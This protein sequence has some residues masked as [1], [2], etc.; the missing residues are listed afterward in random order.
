MLA[1]GLLVLVAIVLDAIR[2]VRRSRYEKIR[3]PRRKQPIFDDDT[4]LDEYGSELPS[5]GARVVAQRDQADLEEMTRSL[6]DIAEASKPKLTIPVRKP[7]QSALDLGEQ[8]EQVV[9][10][11]QEKEDAQQ[12]PDHST[13]QA[14][15]AGKVSGQVLVLHLMATERTPFKGDL[16]LNAFLACGLRYGDMKIFHYHAGD[17]GAGEVL[18]SIASSVNPGV[19]NLKTIAEFK[20][21]GISL[22]FATDD[23]TN[24]SRAFEKMLSTAEALAKRLG[25]QLRD[26]NRQPLTPQ[27]IEQCRQLVAEAA[28]SHSSGNS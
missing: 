18:F 2:R 23:V 26:E 3:M 12:K 17:N 16:L 25:G 9:G 19:F 20:T 5:G 22:F 27:K 10:Q 14:E 15:T 11:P 4:P 6:K 24:P 21:P 13:T 8:P 7:E 28:P 1:L